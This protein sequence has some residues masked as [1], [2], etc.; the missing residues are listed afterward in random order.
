MLEGK[1]EEEKLMQLCNGTVV[2]NTEQ[3]QKALRYS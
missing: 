1:K 2:Q 3:L